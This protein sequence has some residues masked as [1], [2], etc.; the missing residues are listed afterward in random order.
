MTQLN[1]R[2]NLSQCRNEVGPLSM[3]SRCEKNIRCRTHGCYFV[4]CARKV[5]LLAGAQT[6]RQPCLT[7]D[8]SLLAIIGA[9]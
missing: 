4:A 8:G 1:A 2:L 3:R 9:L 5:E 7:Q 6:L